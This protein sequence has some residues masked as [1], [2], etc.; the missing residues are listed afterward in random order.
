MHILSAG[1]WVGIDVI[2]AVLAVS[3]W[4]ATDLSLRGLAYEALGRFVVVPMLTAGLVC[5]ASGVL[6]G[7]G[8]RHGPYATGGWRSSSWSTSCCA[9]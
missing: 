9:C 5:L 3:G 7:L 4:F 2:V 8:T 6:L 1:A